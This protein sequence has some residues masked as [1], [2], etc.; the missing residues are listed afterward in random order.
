M[1]RATA[2]QRRAIIKYPYSLNFPGSSVDSVINVG[3]DVY[4]YE[5]TQPW[6]VAFWINPTSY[7]TGTS[8]GHI[9]SDY[10][11]SGTFRGRLVRIDT[12]GVLRF[13]L[14]NTFG[15]NELKANYVAP[16]LG[17]W[18]RVVITYN[19]SSNATGVK[20]YFNNVLQ[21]QSSSTS[22]LTAT[23]VSS[24]INTRWGN[25]GGASGLG[26]AMYLVKPAILNYEMNATQVAD[27]FKLSLWSGVTP[28]DS[29]DLT[30]GAGTTITSSGSGAHNGT[31]GSAVTWGTS[32][33]PIGTRKNLTQAR[34]PIS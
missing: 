30:E 21:T 2:S 1:P 26:Q 22:A 25:W 5:R 6:S 16:P 7:L 19:G 20:C 11:A 17:A 4:N 23:I 14:I 18:T 9:F 8:V 27:D 31:L 28:I 34:L 32:I 12:S 15:S 13:W 29:Y 33:V 10:L 24:G 3:T